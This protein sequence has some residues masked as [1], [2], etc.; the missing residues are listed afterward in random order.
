M[1][2]GIIT[3]SPDN[4]V[5]LLRGFGPFNALARQH[6]ELQILRPPLSPSGEPMVDW[7]WLTTLD[8]LFLSAPYRPWQ[9][10][11]VRTAKMAGVPVWIDW[12]DDLTCV[13]R[14]N[15]AA[16]AFPFEEV[17]PQL[18]MLTGLADVITVTTQELYRRRS[19]E[20]MAD[21]A[22]RCR[23]PFKPNPNVHLIPNA[24]PKLETSNLKLETSRAKRVTWRGG[25][26]HDGDILEVLPQLA[27]IS[28]LPQYSLWK[29][30]FI[31]TI[32][33]LVAEQMNPATF[34]QDPGADAFLYL[35]M[36]SALAPAI[37]IVP[38]KDNA[39]NRCR[40]NLAWLEA[41]AAGAVVLAPDW[42]EWRRPGVINYTT[43]TNF[44]SKLR[45]LLEGQIPLASNHAQSAA[46]IRENLLLEK[47]NAQ[48][49]QILQQLAGRGS[50]TAQIKDQAA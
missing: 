44:G 48:R 37:H 35:R 39:F 23:T 30:T 4:G 2:L 16:H 41:T 36:F 45:G 50:S 49:W 46:Y 12:D 9:T 47:T 26:N 21:L 17:A 15:P 14:Y 43:P 3:A 11:A 6:P 27:E 33:W 13:P 8:C 38:L 5:S 25:N 10:N 7:S 24:I 19:P 1:K 29:W 28:R 34:E 22:K 42:E 32:P 20:A 40:S 18:V 31:G